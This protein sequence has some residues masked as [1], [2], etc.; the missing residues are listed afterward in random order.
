MSTARWTLKEA[1]GKGL[2]RRTGSAEK[3]AMLDEKFN[4]FKVQTD[5]ESMVV[6]ATGISVKVG[7][8]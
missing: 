4:I 5:P 2:A 3:A 1:A 7:V 6:N 8:H